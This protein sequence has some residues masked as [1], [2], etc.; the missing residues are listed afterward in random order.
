MDARKLRRIK[1]N[2]R[3]CLTGQYVEGEIE[4]DMLSK[5]ALKRISHTKIRKIIKEKQFPPLSAEEKAE[6]DQIYKGYP[7]FTYDYHRVFKGLTGKF[8]PDYMPED[9]YYCYIEDSFSDKEASRYIDNKCYYPRIFPT[10][11][12][13]EPVIFRMG[14]VWLDTEYRPLSSKE[15]LN[16]LAQC[17]GDLIMK[18]AENSERSGGV[19]LLKEKERMDAF[20]KNIKKIPRGLDVIVQKVIRQHMDYAVLNPG[21]VNA[22]RVITYLNDKTNEVEILKLNIRIGIDDTIS[23]TG[24]RG[25]VLAGVD[26]DGR[27]TPFTYGLDGTQYTKHPVYDYNFGDITVPYADRIIEYVKKG[28]PMVSRFKI[29]SWDIGIDEAG[30][31]VL[32]EVNLTMSGIFY[33]QLVDGPLFG[34]KTTTK[35]IL[36]KVFKK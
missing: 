16:T 30:D 34:G 21:S 19:F 13:P 4:L 32:M 9:L 28:H 10:L 25:G 11:K 36:K 14:G 3:T 18:I 20:R 23:N 24:G 5:E 27:L 29:I 6:V 1:N 15:V 26:P 12:Q 35:E 2:I 17:K 22:Y 33:N 7:F 8:Y 31:P